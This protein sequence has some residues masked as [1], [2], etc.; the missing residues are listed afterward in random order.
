MNSKLIEQAEAVLADIGE[1]AIDRPDLLPL[2]NAL[3]AAELSPTT[4]N[5]DAL[6]RELDKLDA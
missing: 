5:T 4:I 1:V 6:R 2:I 3:Q